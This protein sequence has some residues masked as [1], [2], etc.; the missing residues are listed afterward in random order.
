M[1][2]ERTMC[3]GRGEAAVWSVPGAATFQ[4]YEEAHALAQRVAEYG[5]LM[6]WL[7]WGSP[8]RCA[9]AGCLRC[10]RDLLI[11]RTRHGPFRLEGTALSGCVPPH[12]V[13]LDVVSL[14][15]KIA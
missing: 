2:K 3:S 10:G 9:K 12:V 5:H 13:P 7:T 11:V 4:S 14:V 8:P 6:Q 1:E 15:R